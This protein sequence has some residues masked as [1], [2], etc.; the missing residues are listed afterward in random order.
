MLE[1]HGITEKQQVINQLIQQVVSIEEST[2]GT[3]QCDCLN[4]QL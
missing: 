1:I 4:D 2:P 3:E